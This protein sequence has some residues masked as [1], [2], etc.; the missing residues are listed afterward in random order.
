MHSPESAPGRGVARLGS[1]N[2]MPP[3][4]SEADDPRI[5][6]E[7]AA[8]LQPLTESF[9][10]LADDLRCSRRHVEEMDRNGQLGPRPIKLGRRRVFLRSEIQEWLAARAP[11]RLVW[12]ARKEDRR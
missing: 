8:G 9:D 6:A 3:A 2:Q 7:E 12:S 1:G 11:D 10:E 4:L 5:V